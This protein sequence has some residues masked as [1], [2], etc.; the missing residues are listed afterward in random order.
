[1]GLELEAIELEYQGKTMNIVVD[2]SHLKGLYE[3][4]QYYNASGRFTNDPIHGYS[5]YFEEDE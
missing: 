5:F 3:D 4:V 1:M 2:L